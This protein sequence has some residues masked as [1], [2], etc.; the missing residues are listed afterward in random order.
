MAAQ[1]KNYEDLKFADDFIFC[2]V[3][4]N[5]PDFCHDLAELI[6]NRKAGGV[7]RLG[8]QNDVSGDLNLNAFLEYVAENRP[9]SDFPLRLDAKVKEAREHKEWRKEYMSLLER[10][11]RMREEGREKERDN[12][13]RE[14]AR[15]DAA[16]EELACTKALLAALKQKYEIGDS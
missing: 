16:E 2:K 5:N 4:S 14:A 15:A 10:D 13:R 9:A 1:S 12:T 3:L 8:S 11:E 6:L 7:I